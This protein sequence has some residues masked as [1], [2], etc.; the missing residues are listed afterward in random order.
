MLKYQFVHKH[1]LILIFFL[2]TCSNQHHYPC[3]YQV[4]NNRQ[5][6]TT[7]SQK[8]LVVEE[9][10]KFLEIKSQILN[11]YIN[12]KG[13]TFKLGGLD[14]SGIDCSAFVQNTFREQFGINLPRTTQ[15]QK[16][17]GVTVQRNN[18]L[19]GDLVLFYNHATGRHIGM[20]ISYDIFLHASSSSGIIISN[21]NDNYWNHSYYE[22]RRILTICSLHEL[23]NNLK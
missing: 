14:K 5:L 8:L 18:L 3:Y 16:A 7:N 21:L 13:V 1:I 12:W 11:Q 9:I 19:P 20:Y 10:L 6:L 22:G 15:Y 4:T 17:I 2:S 23:L